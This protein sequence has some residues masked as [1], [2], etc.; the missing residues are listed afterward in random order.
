MPSNEPD[1]TRVITAIA[2][3]GKQAK[4]CLV[5]KKPHGMSALV[6]FERVASVARKDCGVTAMD[7]DLLEFP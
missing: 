3:G 1:T 5:T 7:I 6:Q 2:C 4:T